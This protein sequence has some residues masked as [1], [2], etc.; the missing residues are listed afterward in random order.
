MFLEANSEQPSNSAFPT[1]QPSALVRASEIFATDMKKRGQ[2]LARTL[3]FEACSYRI[4]K[5]P[6]K[7][8]FKAL[9]RQC[10]DIWAKLYELFDDAINAGIVSKKEIWGPFW[11]GF[12]RF[13]KNL[14]IVSSTC[15]FIWAV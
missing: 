6:L 5:A 4:E 1:F 7:D 14:C 3:S 8:E 11:G 10:C 9:H 15:P 13:F 2:Y 12:Q